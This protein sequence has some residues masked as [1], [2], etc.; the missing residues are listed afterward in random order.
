MSISEH[1]IQRGLFHLRYC[2]EGTGPVLFIVGDSHYYQRVFSSNLRQH[3]K[4]IF[5]DH[6]GFADSPGVLDS[7]EYEL[8]VIID[9]MEALRQALNIDKMFVLGH[10][11][12]AYMALEYAKKFEK[13]V[14]GVVMM[15]IAPDLSAKSTAEADAYWDALADD[16]RKAA[17]V[18]NYEQTTDD[19][20]EKMSYSDRF[21]ADY[22]RKTPKIW[23]DY[24]FDSA[25]LFSQSTFNEQMITY[26]WGTVFQNIDITKNTEHFNLPVWVAIGKYDGLVAPLESWD[27][28]RGAFND[29]TITIFEK[30]G[31]TPQFE[32]P[33]LFD[34][35]LIAW[36][37]SRG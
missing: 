34:H 15:G 33:E 11:G 29:M 14:I 28:V 26:V 3:F 22:V 30:S 36:C 37:S 4:I 10:S 2:T 12:H 32:E 16:D 13:H 17:L 6:R 1:S 21:I 23:Y 19:D 7:S 35:D 8:D 24:T 25:P 5:M 9:D 20:L 31:H 27:S 18:K